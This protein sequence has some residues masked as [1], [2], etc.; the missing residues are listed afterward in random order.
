MIN[1]KQIFSHPRV[2]QAVL[3]V[4]QA[5][6][7]V[8]LPIFAKC[9]KD[10][11]IKITPNRIRTVGGG[12]KGDLRTVEDKL[13]YILLYLKIYPTYDALSVL[14]NHYRSKCQDS[15]KFLLP[16]IEMA[17][18]RKFALPKRKS[19]G[20]SLE[21]IFQEFPEV[22]DVFMDGTERKVQ[23]PNNLKKR[24]RLYSGK[25]KATTRKSIVISDEKKYIH[26]L[27]RTK[28]G[29]RHDKRLADK[30]GLISGLPPD[31]ALWTDTG[32]Q[33]AARLHEN[34]IM[35]SKATKNRPLTS[36]QKE[37]NHLISSFRVVSEHAIA[38][39]KRFKAA[40]DTYRNHLP[41]LDDLFTEVSIGLW[42]F[43]LQQTR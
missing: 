26:Y 12:R 34:T 2:T 10:Y 5:E 39:F 14:T 37:E 17:L 30:E 11:R 36:A 41:N 3:G 32:F 33:G 25:K 18:D 6:F 8:L 1:T 29:R 40:S 24:N 22:R 20:R 13:I 35:P 42:N 19:N 4:S 21:E 9:L 27:S 15:V 7:E 28:S 38:G 23:R 31:I 43:H 16:V